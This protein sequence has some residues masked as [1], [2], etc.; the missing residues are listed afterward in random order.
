MRNYLKHLIKIKLMLWSFLTEDNVV[1]PDSEAM[2]TL[3][4]ALVL[5]VAALDLTE[6]VALDF[7]EV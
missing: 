7:F 2:P 4:E 1:P 5:E 6:A 3:S